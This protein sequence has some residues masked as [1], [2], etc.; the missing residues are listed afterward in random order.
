MENGHKKE[1]GIRTRVSAQETFG[2]GTR[3]KRMALGQGKKTTEWQEV[4]RNYA[5]G[6]NGRDARDLDV[7]QPLKA[8]TDSNQQN[9]KH[10][11]ATAKLKKNITSSKP[12]RI[13]ANV[14][15]S[16]LRTNTRPPEVRKKLDKA[17]VGGREGRTE[18]GG[19]NQ[20]KK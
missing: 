1:Q 3:G 18:C 15:C 8:V 9:A 6:V 5:T 14:I 20:R 11:T 12:R 13:A 7:I 17:S 16:V 4:E 2:A 10:V 19:R